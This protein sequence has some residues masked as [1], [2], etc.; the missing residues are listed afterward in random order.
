M[1]RLDR[2]GVAIFVAPDMV[3]LDKKNIKARGRWAALAGGWGLGGLAGG[4]GAGAAGLRAGWP[5][6]VGSLT[7]LPGLLGGPA[8]ACAASHTHTPHS[9]LTTPTPTPS[10]TPQIERAM[11]LS[12]SP[13][14]PLLAVYQAGENQQPAKLLMYSLPSKTVGGAPAA[15]AA[16][17]AAVSA[18]GVAGAVQRRAA[19]CARWP[20]PRRCGLHARCHRQRP[21]QDEGAPGR[22]RAP[23]PP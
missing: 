22:P 6:L 20:A 8:G 11:D 13:S 7:G 4:W 14:E 16:A 12:F 9:P 23:Q 21:A 2:D 15:A 18:A 3:K 5:G 19:C 17:A 1:A 10:T